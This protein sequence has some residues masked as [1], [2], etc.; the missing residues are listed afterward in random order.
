MRAG[1]MVRR[2]RKASLMFAP[3]DQEPP[4]IHALPVP[5]RQRTRRRVVATL[6]A[7]AVTA[8][9]AVAGAAPALA[10]VPPTV[11][12]FS[13]TSGP[14]G[15]PVTILGSGFT[16]ATAVTFNTATSQFTATVPASASTG[17][18]NVTTPGG[19]GASTTKFTVDPGIV[20]SAPG[21][22][23]AGTVTVSGAGFKSFE[24]V[25]LFFDATDETLTGTNS[26]GTFS[27]ATV[28]V[29]A[30]T[31]PGTRGPTRMR[32][33]CPHRPSPGLTRTGAS[34]PV[35]GSR[36]RLPWST[37]WSTLAP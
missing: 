6:L 34:P 17:T 12:S 8:G 10:A 4:L 5:A 13:P 27:G 32:T 22:H 2:T 16:G 24:G 11:S 29:P 14:I 25:D 26:T 23:P 20:L 35:T 33:C 19:T 15:T 1:L 18:I 36:R 28:A 7:V 30:S 9:A 3:Q 31:L 37:G 21:G